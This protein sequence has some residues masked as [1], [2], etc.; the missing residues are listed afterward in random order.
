MP[1]CPLAFVF[2]ELCLRPL[3]VARQVHPKFEGPIYLTSVKCKFFAFPCGIYVSSLYCGGF[4]A[5]QDHPK[6][7]ELQYHLPSFKN[8]VRPFRL[9]CWTPPCCPQR[10]LVV[11][12]G[13]SCAGKSTQVELK[14]DLMARV[15]SICTIMFCGKIFLY[16]YMFALFG[17]HFCLFQV[18]ISRASYFCVLL[19]PFI[20]W[21]R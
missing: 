5:R 1:G 10:L 9:V 18:K 16:V 20:C 21:L 8:Q 17:R 4:S 15:K 6:K 12:F 7:K 11:G 14:S 3:F 19:R 2:I 13:A